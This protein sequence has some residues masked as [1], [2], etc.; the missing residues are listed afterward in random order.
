MHLEESFRDNLEVEKNN[1][2][3]DLKELEVSFEV[4]KKFQNY[5]FSR[6]NEYEVNQL[7]DKVNLN[8]DKV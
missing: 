1:F 7:R 2:V 4:I 8:F 3:D 6:E 5:E